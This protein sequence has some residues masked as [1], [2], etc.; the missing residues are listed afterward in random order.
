LEEGG[1]PILDELV[2]G[3]DVVGQAGDDDSGAVAR[4]EADGEAL[5]VL[6]QGDAEVLER[7]LA[8]PPDEVRLGVG[9]DG[10]DDGG[11]EE[12]GDD[13]VEPADV[14]ALDAV[15]DGEL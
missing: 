13:D 10:I 15:V 1:H 12:G 2:E 14:M 9:G 11:E 3:F 7:A 8:D 4:V 6:E 5:E